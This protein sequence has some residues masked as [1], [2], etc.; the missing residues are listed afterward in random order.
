MK[1]KEND[2][3][4]EIDLGTLW[5]WD[6]KLNCKLWHEWNSNDINLSEIIL[7]SRWFLCFTCVLLMHEP[8]GISLLSMCHFQEQR[9]LYACLQLADDCKFKR[10]ISKTRLCCFGYCMTWH[11]DTTSSK[12]TYNT[13]ISNMFV[14]QQ[15]PVIG[16]SMPHKW[17]SEIGYYDGLQCVSDT[18]LRYRDLRA[19]ICIAIVSQDSINLKV[20]GYWCTNPSIGLLFLSFIFQVNV[21]HPSVIS[22][23]CRHTID[24]VWTLKINSESTTDWITKVLTQLLQLILNKSLAIH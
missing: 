12:G 10:Y 24:Q 7:C 9:E 23:Q 6:S 19:I 13:S 14:R 17:R 21:W 2:P 15:V 20:F 22:V 16:L 11:T 5:S 18:G 3:S 1:T 8:A 4:E